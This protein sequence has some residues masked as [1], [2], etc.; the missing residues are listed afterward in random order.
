[1]ITFGST[2]EVV[3]P[4]TKEIIKERVILYVN[5]NDPVFK[6]GQCIQRETWDPIWKVNKIGKEKYFLVSV[7]ANHDGLWEPGDEDD[8]HFMYSKYF[9]EVECP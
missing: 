4:A 9:S 2:P 5:M 1:M 3:C 8:Q 6:I 7:R